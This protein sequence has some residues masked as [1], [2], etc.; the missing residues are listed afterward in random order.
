MDAM[1][2]DLKMVHYKQNPMSIKRK[3]EISQ[4]CCILRVEMI[5]QV[6]H[7]EQKKCLLLCFLT[8]KA[9]DD[10]GPFLAS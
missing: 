5:E 3:E 4:Y 1:M 7:W 6:I 8:K 9:K 10:T 2:M